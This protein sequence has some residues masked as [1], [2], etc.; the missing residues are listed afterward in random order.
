M[1]GD[2][3][4]LKPDSTTVYILTLADAAGEIIDQF[5]VYVLVRFPA[6]GNAVGFT[7][8][9]AGTAAGPLNPSRQP[10][11]KSD[12]NYQRW[13]EMTRDVV[14]EDITR[15]EQTSILEP[16]VLLSASRKISFDETEVEVANLNPFLSPRVGHIFTSG[17]PG[18]M[19]RFRLATLMAG[20][21]NIVRRGGSWANEFRFPRPVP[22]PKEL[23]TFDP[24]YVAESEKTEW[25]TCS[26]EAMNG[27]EPFAFYGL[28]WQDPIFNRRLHAAA[29]ELVQGDLFL[30]LD[31]AVY[32]GKDL[33]YPEIQLLPGVPANWKVKLEVKIRRTV[34]FQLET[35]ES[36]TFEITKTKVINNGFPGKTLKI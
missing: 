1:D 30:G 21:D 31:R 16:G 25:P 17:R 18:A 4:V 8:K 29:Q 14:F 23:F 11:S 36:M 6:A 22:L 33:C 15:S 5:E 34:H 2:S 32:G 19:M 28:A 12:D 26:V 20:K 35:V 3:Q 27:P 7:H 13:L 10:Q 24:N 9:I